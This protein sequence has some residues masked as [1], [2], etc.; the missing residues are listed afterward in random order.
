VKEISNK[1][2]ERIIFWTG[3][4]FFLI[5]FFFAFVFFLE[6]TL[7]VD[8]AFFAFKMLEYKNFSIELGRW[9]S[10]L[11]QILPLC[12]IR[13]GLSLRSVLQVFSLSYILD[14]FLIFLLIVR[15]FKN[16]NYGLV[17]LFTLC[18]GFRQAFYYSSAELYQ[19][20]SVTVLFWTM[21]NYLYVNN[22]IGSLARYLIWVFVYTL[23]IAISYFHQLLVFPCIFV[24]VLE[25]IE[26]K[27]YK[28]RSFWLLL[29][30]TA[31]WFFIR[32]FL[33]TNT[34]Y[35]HDKM[36]S[37]QDIMRYLPHIKSLPSYNYFCHYYQRHLWLA[38]ILLG[39]G[40][41]FLLK[42]RKWF[43]FL[44]VS[45]TLLI[46]TIL[47]II[48]YHNGGSPVMYENYYTVFGLFIGATFVISLNKELKKGWV[49]ISM[50]IILSLNLS[51]IYK[52]HINLTERI[53]Y[54]DRL[55]Q[56]GQKHEGRKY[57]IDQRNFLWSVGWV[58]WALPFE[59]LIYSSVNKQF[60]PVSYYVCG[61]DKHV[62]DSL[63]NRPNIFLGPPWAITWFKSMNLNRNYYQLPSTG[64]KVMN[65]YQTDSTL[66]DR[67]YNK[68]NFKI[69]AL[70]DEYEND[71][72]YTLIIPVKLINH[73]GREIPSL[74]GEC[75]KSPTCI[76]YHV[77]DKRGHLITYDGL[78]SKLELDIDEEIL[79]GIEVE[80]PSEPGDY[81]IQ[82]DMVT[83]G[84]KWWNCLERCNLHVKRKWYL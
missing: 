74:L 84:K 9:G 81:I 46:Y 56:N 43:T 45:A 63:M 58:S 70:K 2:F 35:E 52:A 57:I 78:R 75:T 80:M 62:V 13:L 67:N 14:Y 48:T 19:G 8:A 32:I 20:L 30:W 61:E 37:Y 6:R 53:E 40:L 82:F 76:S 77:F 41:F 65:T 72:D 68:E 59:S 29:S 15:V 34:A 3:I 55:T 5:L 60:D 51:G 16:Y 28:E 44:F 25:L 38:S 54:F 42:K 33:L 49:L 66:D 1:I 12:A 73:S 7:C 18:L 23:V 10:V 26:N 69:Q 50:L 47:I 83:E 31:T 17:L 24:L 39:M 11:P 71:A 79:Q 21:V 4:V 22:S 64:Y 27:R 36:I